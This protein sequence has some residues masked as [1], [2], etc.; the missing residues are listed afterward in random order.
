VRALPLADFGIVNGAF[1][2][3]SNEFVLSLSSLSLSLL[4]IRVLSPSHPCFFLDRQ[5]LRAEQ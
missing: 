5:L 4:L 3:H 2:H 1:D